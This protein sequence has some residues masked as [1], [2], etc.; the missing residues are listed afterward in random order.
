MSKANGM[1]KYP[2]EKRVTNLRKLTRVTDDN[3]LEQIRVRHFW[4]FLCLKKRGLLI[5]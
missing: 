2:D 1:Q 4:L 5:N 3:V